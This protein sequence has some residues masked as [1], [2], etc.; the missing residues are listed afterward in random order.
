MQQPGE[1]EETVEIRGGFRFRRLITMSAVALLTAISV[2]SA[3]QATPTEADAGRDAPSH[4]VDERGPAPPDLELAPQQSSDTPSV[5]T[6]SNGN[7]MSALPD[8]EIA[9]YVFQQGTD[10]TSVIIV[11]N[12]NGASNTA[13]LH[14]RA[15]GRSRRRL[16]VLRL[17]EVVVPSIA[18]G[19]FAGVDMCA[20][21]T[22]DQRGAAAGTRRTATSF[23]ELEL[24]IEQVEGA[25]VYLHN[26]SATLHIDCI[27]RSAGGMNTEL[28]LTVPAPFSR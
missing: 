14:L 12:G 7:G 6:V 13:I 4:A 2:A 15:V 20:E 28:G 9:P 27:S 18:P 1:Q 19:G 11:N 8:L 16:L 3:A 24:T 21:F 23:T 22:E 10:A 25:E 5:V 17:G 26:N